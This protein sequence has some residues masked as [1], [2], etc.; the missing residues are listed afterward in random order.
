MIEHN[1]ISLRFTP[2][3]LKEILVIDKNLKAL[4]IKTNL[5]LNKKYKT[6]FSDEES[7]KNIYFIDFFEIIRLIQKTKKLKKA[8]KVSSF[9][10]YNFSIFNLFLFQYLAI[11]K[12][13]YK[14]IYVLHEPFKENPFRLNKSFLKNLIVNYININSSKMITDI[15]LLSDYAN[16]IFKSQKQYSSSCRIF[17]NK[18]ILDPIL[19]N[20]KKKERIYNTFLGRVTEEK[21]INWFLSLAK[22]CGEKGYKE[23]FLILSSSNLPIL[24]IEKI[25]SKYKN[26]LTINPKNLDEK[27]IS[28]YLLLSKSVFIMHKIT[29]SGVF[30]ESIRHNTPIIFKDQISLT[31]EMLLCGVSVED[32][33]A[34]N[35][36]NGIKKIEN[37]FDYYQRNC[38]KI[39][40]D[41]FSSINFIKY[42]DFLI[43]K[44]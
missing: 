39:F 3:L 26:L 18:I 34:N 31:K 6:F 37:N 16:E 25:N 43:K 19:K 36:F 30:V 14:R 13:N 5:Y 44:N 8:D 20:P 23:K 10:I 2:G 40:N 28:Y 41:K 22:F 12:P 1:L 15:V 21:K 38:K 42:Y 7:T 4:G 33:I 9:F 24:E 17:N 27:T 35:I 11:F 32:L 29:Q